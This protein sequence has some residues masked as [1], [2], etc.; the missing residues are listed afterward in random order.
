MDACRTAAAAGCRIG[1]GSLPAQPARDAVPHGRS[2]SRR[3]RGGPHRDA[4]CTG[5][6][7]RRP[8]TADSGLPAC[9]WNWARPMKAAA[10]GRSR[11]PDPNSPCRRP[12]SSPPSVRPSR[13]GSLGAQG[14]RS[15][16]D[17]ASRSIR[18][19]WPP[20]SR[21]CSPAVT[22]V[23]GAD[24]AVRA[25]AA[26]KLAAVSIDQYLG[27]RPVGRSGNDQRADDQNGRTE[28]A[29]FFREV[30]QTPRAPMPELPV[31]ERMHNF[32]EVELG[33]S[34]A[35]GHAGIRPL[36]ELRLLESL[37]LPAPAVLRPNMV[38]TRCASPVR[39]ANS[40]AT[41]LT[42]RSFTSPAS[43]S[44]AAP[45]SPPRPWP[46]TD[47]DWPLSDADS[48]PRSRFP[49]RGRWSRPCPPP[50]GA[51][52]KSAPPAPSRSRNPGAAA[53]SP[54]KTVGEVP[55]CER[56]EPIGENA[57]AIPDILIAVLLGFEYN[58]FP[59]GKAGVRYPPDRGFP[60]VCLLVG[61]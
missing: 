15:R 40:T 23:T 48:K 18:S 35:N 1:H 28:I 49:S 50:P 36:H 17:G 33:Y 20:I 16:D 6:G 51:P 54:E 27:G 37:H 58:T 32:D 43:A 25:V 13:A 59:S 8:L 4:G 11:F 30:E 47:W 60:R 45:A 55:T 53:I 21:G 44:S 39:A 2:G 24:L 26:G 31:E 9:A 34:P 46:G 42:R 19:R 3:G 12:A 5:C 57:F 29:E 22:R 52:P 41:P 56:V 14:V 38:R 10:R 61:R 7:S